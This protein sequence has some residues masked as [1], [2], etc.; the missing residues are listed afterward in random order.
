MKILS[1]GVTHFFVKFT[2]RVILGK[3]Y[4]IILLIIKKDL[5]LKNCSHIV[6]YPERFQQ[7]AVG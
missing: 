7:L 2:L 1:Y 3:T 6:K 4:N 5:L